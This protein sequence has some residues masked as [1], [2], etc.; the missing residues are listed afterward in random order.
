M[1]NSALV[2]YI[3]QYK[4]QYS[5]NTLRTYLIQQGYD[6]K[7]VDEAINATI[8]KKPIIL[9]ILI[10]LA[11]IF[12]VFLI[13]YFF[14]SQKIELH[15]KITPEKT[16]VLQEETLFFSAIFGTNTEEQGIFNYIL[17]NEKNERLIE[18]TDY[19]TVKKQTTKKFPLN[20]ANLPPGKYNLKLYFKIKN[21]EANDFFVFE[22]MTEQINKTIIQEVKCPY[23]CDDQ[24]PTTKDECIQGNCVNTMITQC[25]NDSCDSNETVLSCPQDCKPKKI[26]TQMDLKKT[27][28]SMARSDPEQAANTCLQLTTGDDDCLSELNESTDNPAFC[29]VINNLEIKD[30]C[31]S[32]YAL[33]TNDYTI[34]N[35]ITDTKQQKAC[36]NVKKLSNST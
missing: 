36:F 17:F 10:V 6:P 19:L 2:E 18:E 33:R 22:I 26:I 12:S 5:I 13:Y 1:V 34:C 4:S 9:P 15:V 11:L 24:N 32:S 14:P 7:D 30:S 31:Y 29:N 25:G 8:K 3:N 27:A 21:E 35:L 20:L 28:L 23:S 16:T